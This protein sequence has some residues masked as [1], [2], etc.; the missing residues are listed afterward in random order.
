MI[1]DSEKIVR[2]NHIWGFDLIYFLNIILFI[3]TYAHSY[4]LMKM[5]GI[6]NGVY[7]LTDTLPMY[8]I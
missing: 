7:F 8:R 3:D 6:V 1:K 5:I 4:C 2:S